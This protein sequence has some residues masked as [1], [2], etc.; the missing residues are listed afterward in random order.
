[1]A[2]LQ[3]SQAGVG[4][5][6]MSRIGGD[7]GCGGRS[8]YNRVYERCLTTNGHFRSVYAGKHVDLFSGGDFSGIVEP[9]L[10]DD[11]LFRL[12][13]ENIRSIRRY[14]Q[15]T[16]S[17]KLADSF[18]RF[19]ELTYGIEVRSNEEILVCSGVNQ[20]LD[21]ISR[22]FTGRVVYMPDFSVPF[23]RT[24]PAANGAELATYP[25]GMRGRLDVAKLRRILETARPSDIRFIYLNYP[26]NP[27]GG[28]LTLPEL[29]EVVNEARKRDIVLV[30]DHDICFTH[31]DHGRPINSIFQ[32]KHGI[33]AGVELY[34]FSKEF[35][36]AGIRVGIIVGHRD[37]VER[38]R[39]HNWDF[40]I[41]VPTVDQM[42]ADAALA[43]I[44]PERIRER[45]SAAMNVLVEGFRT[46]GWHALDAPDSGIAFRLRVP[47]SFCEQQ[48]I[49]ASELFAFYLQSRV[50]IGLA[51]GTMFGEYGEGW[52]R[53]E[54]MQE[55]S[56]LL[57]V[58]E[59]LAHA[60]IDQDMEMPREVILEMVE[61]ETQYGYR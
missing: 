52:L 26:N 31:Y 20:A 12:T 36:L 7:L 53:V 9:Y 57:G 5:G 44:D 22:T 10:D 59:R 39:R 27:T 50:G 18:A 16:T 15:S 40:G 4:H 56:T 47:E 38:L 17:S 55:Q 32:T 23:S 45:F 37:L 34:T 51:P 41:M 11:S 28:N 42:I 60:G 1:M 46:L 54:I 35:C 3:V 21:A 25:M 33:D 8:P 61:L 2:R 48:E 6:S 19:L 58:I 30:S 24:I 43:R 14:P 29:N 13:K 49:P